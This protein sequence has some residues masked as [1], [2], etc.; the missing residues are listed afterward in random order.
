[1]TY[2]ENNDY[3]KLINSNSQKFNNPIRFPI[4]SA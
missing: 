3:D 4:Q 2:N 1:M